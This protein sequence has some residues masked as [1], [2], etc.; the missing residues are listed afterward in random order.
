MRFI[1]L[2]VF[3]LLFM[4]PGCNSQ[5]L[6]NRKAAVAGSFYS[7]DPEVLKAD[8]RKFFSQAKPCTSTGNV[9]A[10]ISPHAGYVFSGIVAASAFIQ[11]DKNKKYDNV[12]VIGS[13]HRVAFDGAAIYNKGNFE[14]PL[15]TFKVN[16]ELANKLI[17][18]YDVFIYHDQAH[19]SE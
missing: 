11:I 3:I 9:L 12:F 16:L 19:T 17:D 5:N 14:T 13:S 8:L 1:I 2:S 6:Q 10:I 18:D 15:G 7:S 4:T